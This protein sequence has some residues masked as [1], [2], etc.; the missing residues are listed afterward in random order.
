MLPRLDCTYWCVS[1]R[2]EHSALPFERNIKISVGVRHPFD[3]LVDKAFV[4]IACLVSMGQP[5]LLSRISLGF[6]RRVPLW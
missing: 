3:Y 4:A 5:S 6:Y 2:V 1:H